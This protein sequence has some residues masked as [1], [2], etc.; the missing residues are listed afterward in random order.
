M[1]AGALLFLNSGL[2]TFLGWGI[3]EAV[4]TKQSTENYQ[5]YGTLK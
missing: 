5:S 4:T 3:A 1:I 2:L